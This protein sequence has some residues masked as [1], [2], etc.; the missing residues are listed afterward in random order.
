MQVF[1]QK[2][3][4]IRFQN[5]FEKSLFLQRDAVLRR[6][7]GPS[8]F[9]LETLSPYYVTSGLALEPSN[10]L[11]GSAG[12]HHPEGQ[13]PRSRDYFQVSGSNRRKQS[14]HCLQ[15][16]CSC[17]SISGAKKNR[18]EDMQSS[19]SHHRTKVSHWKSGLQFRK[20]RHLRGHPWFH[21]IAVVACTRPAGCW[22]LTRIQAL[23][24][25]FS[26]PLKGR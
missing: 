9:G 15:M 2:S 23:P 14:A 11:L 21:V 12:P 10:M 1:Q 25:S 16:I 22:F 7:Y 20:L 26:G 8:N 17:R 18:T 4:P 5:I 3:S 6:R 19:L 13:K 24:E